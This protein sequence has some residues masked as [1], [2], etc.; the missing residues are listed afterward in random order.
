LWIKCNPKKRTEEFSELF[1]EVV[2]LDQSPINFVEEIILQ[3]KLVKCNADCFNL[4]LAALDQFRKQAALSQDNLSKVISLGG[5][6]TYQSVRDVFNFRELTL[7]SYP[8]LPEL[9]RSH[10]SVKVSESILCI[11]GNTSKGMFVKP[12]KAVFQIN[13]KNHELKWQ[14]VAS[15]KEER[16]KMGAALYQN[17]I[18]VVGGDTG[19]SSLKSVEV[20]EP[21]L[22]EW[23]T[24]S[25][26]NQP[27]SD[28][29]LVTCK[30]SLLTI[31]GWDRRTYF[32]SVE[33]LDNWNGDWKFVAPMMT[34]RICF[35][36]VN[37][38]GVVYAIGG[39]SGFLPTSTMKS[40][41]KYDINAN[42]WTYVSDMNIERTG[43][44]ACVLDG[45]IFVFGGRNSKWDVVREIECY[46]P[47]NNKWNI[48]GETNDKLYAHAIVAV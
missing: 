7:E 28:H 41:E 38:N 46:N 2:V 4:T 23:K 36:A 14:K 9:L 30:G 31:G 3:E 33:Q 34:P 37:C 1:K 11:G 8:K 47:S 18:V 17:C 26:I 15:M 12:T 39:Q 43:L 35:A 48:V 20:F 32:S 21:D 19:T 10:C 25:P 5:Y 22:D 45:K 40:V 13:V 24:I 16:C 27:R 42:T 6:Y 29:A 44:S